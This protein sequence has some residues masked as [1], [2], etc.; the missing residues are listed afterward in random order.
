MADVTGQSALNLHNT[1]QSYLIM[2]DPDSPGRFNKDTTKLTSPVTDKLHSDITFDGK[3]LWNVS[4]ANRL[5]IRLTGKVAKR[6]KDDT[7]NDGTLSVTLM[8]GATQI[9]T[10]DPT[11]QYLNDDGSL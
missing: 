4:S 10:T 5:V 7:P 1:K 9:P 6:D 2:T 8:N 11:V 3:I